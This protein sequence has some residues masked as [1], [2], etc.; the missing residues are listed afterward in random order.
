MFVER[1][2]PPPAVPQMDMDLHFAKA[3][4][5]WRYA[6]DELPPGQTIEVDDLAEDFSDLVRTALKTATPAQLKQAT[7]AVFSRTRCDPQP[8]GG[9]IEPVVE[10][11]GDPATPIDAQG[12]DEAL[13]QPQAH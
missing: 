4:Q 1:L 6:D 10:A 13:D 8:A 12:T 2:R 11:D 3:Q 9:T 7:D 5:R